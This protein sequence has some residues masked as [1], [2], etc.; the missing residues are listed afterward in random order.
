MSGV[1]VKIANP[2]GTADILPHQA[3]AWT[4]CEATARGL[5]KTY[6]YKE[7]RTPLFEE[8]SL[9]KRSLGETTEVVNKQLLEVKSQRSESDEAGFALRPEG[10]AAVVRAYNQYDLGREEFLSK[11]FYKKRFWKNQRA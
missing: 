4:S 3:N 8:S 7:I 1:T 10:T 6:G 5:F 11:L 2:R 9:F